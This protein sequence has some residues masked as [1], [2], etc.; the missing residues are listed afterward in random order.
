VN[1]FQ[2][3]A[4]LVDK[5]PGA[6]VGGFF[7]RC[8]D[9]VVEYD[10][11]AEE[12]RVYFDRDGPSLADAI[13]SGIRDLDAAGLVTVAAGPDDEL[14]TAGA[15]AARLGLD[16]AVL[17]EL[18]DITLTRPVLH[19]AGEPVFRWPQLA[20]RLAVPR[21]DPAIFEAV[22]LALRLRSLAPRVGRLDVIG[23]LVVDFGEGVR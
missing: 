4:A 21:V 13:V 10:A 8:A 15:A 7:A 6:A 23:S 17:D 22:T 5:P 9:A 2:F 12:T 18:L 11:I 14:I 3:G 1:P 19:C 20:E 16:R